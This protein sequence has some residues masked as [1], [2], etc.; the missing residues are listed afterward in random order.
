MKDTWT[1]YCRT[2]TTVM[3]SLD[4][5]LAAGHGGWVGSE[6]LGLW[7]HNIYLNPGKSRQPWKSW[8]TLCRKSTTNYSQTKPP[9]LAM[10]LE[11]QLNH[12]WFPINP[13]YQK[14]GPDSPNKVKTIKI[15]LK[16]RHIG[17][18]LVLLDHFHQTFQINGTATHNAYRGLLKLEGL[19]NYIW[20]FCLSLMLKDN[21]DPI[22]P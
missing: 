8:L 9:L 12:N 4:M 2:S 1:Q 22:R 15:L 11:T 6:V 19:Y 17:Y 13:Q 21:M 20:R 5:I 10:S 3:E 16:R 18:L 7:R 14:I